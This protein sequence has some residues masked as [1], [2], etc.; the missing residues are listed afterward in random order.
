MCQA[1]VYLN[2]Y[3]RARSVWKFWINFVILSLLLQCVQGKVRFFPI[4]S[5]YCSESSV[6]GAM[7]LSPSEIA[8]VCDGESLEFTCSVTRI[9]LEWSFPRLIEPQTSRLHT[10]T[11]TAE[12][13]AESQTFLVTNN[14]TIIYQFTRTSAEGSQP[15]SSRLIIS[16]VSN[17]HNGTAI[18]CSDVTTETA[19]TTIIVVIDNQIQGTYAS[20]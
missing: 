6:S 12:G 15:V 8:E 18:T 11:I 9:L 5:L 19:S 1:I 14:S 3:T 7:M 20:S 16:A 17:S 10:H 2:S 13:P 4:V